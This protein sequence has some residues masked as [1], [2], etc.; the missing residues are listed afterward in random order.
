MLLTGDYVIPDYV[1]S[2]SQY[3]KYIK[4]EQVSGT[5]N[6]FYNALIKTANPPLLC[7]TV[8]NYILKDG[9]GKQI[10]YGSGNWVVDEIQGKVIFNNG[11]IPTELPI[12]IGFC[13][14]SKELRTIVEQILNTTSD[15]KGK[16]YINPNTQV[17]V[18]AVPYLHAPGMKWLVTVTRESVSESFQVATS[19]IDTDVAYVD[20]LKVGINLEYAVDVQNSGST[21]DLLITNNENVLITVNFR[22]LSTV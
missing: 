4:I 21:I 9:K 20:Y 22:R 6:Q 19:I 17:V 8:Y 2:L 12:Y 18:D 1:L 16:V 3:W 13:E 15:N 7:D 5:V 10:L 11:Y 14:M